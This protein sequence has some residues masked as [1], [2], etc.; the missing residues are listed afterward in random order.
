MIRLSDNAPLTDKALQTSMHK[1]YTDAYKLTGFTGGN[2]SYA[3]NTNSSGGA[4]CNPAEKMVPE[5]ERRLGVYFLG[6]ESIE[7]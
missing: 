1:T 7:V 2:W 4:L 5:G 6:W 3:L